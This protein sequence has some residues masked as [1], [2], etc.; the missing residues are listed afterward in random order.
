MM[1]R[2]ERRDV[3]GYAFMIIDLNSTSSTFLKIKVSN[4]GYDYELNFQ[5]VIKLVA[6]YC[7]LE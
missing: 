2:R 6:H 3:G 1:G 7:L 4:Q 5:F